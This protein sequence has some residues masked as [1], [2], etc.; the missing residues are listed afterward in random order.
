MAERKLVVRVEYT[1]GATKDFEIGKVTII[2]KGGRAGM[3]MH[4]DLMQDGRHLLICSDNLLPD[5][6]QLKNLTLVRE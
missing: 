1:D 2:R 6:K 5:D 3:E 4:L